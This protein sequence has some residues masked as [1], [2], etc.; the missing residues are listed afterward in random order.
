MIA[1][2]QEGD[3]ELKCQSFF[4]TVHLERET[5]TYQGHPDMV[6]QFFSTGI[7][8]KDIAENVNVRPVSEKYLRKLKISSY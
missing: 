6:N 1:K 5:V 7:A 2:L 3:E 4:L 8:R